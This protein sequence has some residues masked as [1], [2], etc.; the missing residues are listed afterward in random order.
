ME[1]FENKPA[2]AGSGRND[3]GSAPKASPNGSAHEG[4]FLACVDKWRKRALGHPNDRQ[5]CVGALNAGAAK[6]LHLSQMAIERGFESC[7]TNPLEEPSIQH[8]LNAHTALLRQWHSMMSFEASLE[9]KRVNAEKLI[10]ERQLD[11]LLKK[12]R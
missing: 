10:A 12:A 6:L 11:P 2:E 5:A 3:S 1:G 7:T 8:G 4:A 9:Q